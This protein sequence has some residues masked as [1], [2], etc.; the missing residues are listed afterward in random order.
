MSLLLAPLAVTAQQLQ[1]DPGQRL[2]EQEQRRQAEERL[3]R[4]QSAADNELT[5]R[6]R[7]P[8]VSE[9]EQNA[10]GFFV[11]RL[12]LKDNTLLDDKT[13]RKILARYEDREI[14]RY[15]IDRVINDLTNAYIDAGFIT[16]RVYIPAQNIVETKTLELVAVEGKIETLTVNDNRWPRK[17]ERFMAFP[18]GSGGILQLRDLEQGLDQM[19]RVPSANARM[20]LHPGEQPGET[21]VLITNEP[22]G[23][24]RFYAGY[25]NL[26][27]SSTGRNRVKLSGEADDVL[28][29]NDTWSAYYLGSRD[30]NAIAVTASVPYEWWTLSQSFTYS[31][32]LIGV[33]PGM[34]IFGDTYS[35]VTSLEQVVFRDA[36]QKTSVFGALEVKNSGRILND[37]ILAPQPLTVFRLGARHT[38]R[39]DRGFYAADFTVSQGA[40]IFGAHGNGGLQWDSPH[41]VFTK[42]EAGVSA[43]QGLLDWLSLRSSLRGQF[44]P[45]GLYG[46][47]QIFLGDFNTVRGYINSNAV[48]DDGFYMRNELC[49]NL[50][51]L[52]GIGWLD[53]L[54]T[55]VQPYAFLD[56]GY[57]IAKAESAG[58]TLLGTGVGGRF[59]WDRFTAEV[60]F[61]APLTHSVWL[62]HDQ[63]VTYFTMTLR[64]W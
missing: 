54:I 50:P 20:Q 14:N 31:D 15:Q 7:P 63:P 61:G 43:Y 2:L 25:D 8:T 13:L 40:P 3:L 44:A 32:Y 41:S 34:E 26:G 6:Q 57:A 35:F 21:R 51:P 19:N 17:L 39:A 10:P 62:P 29:L 49:V 37:V 53:W 27:Q 52:A 30:S 1:P 12:I 45:Q 24:Y 46:S 16:T 9:E 58:V 48:G 23:E 56:G 4:Q 60:L 36:R 59:I 22:K 42:L 28:N 33:E 55:K 5:R 38:Y 64:A 47:E 18:T 11:K